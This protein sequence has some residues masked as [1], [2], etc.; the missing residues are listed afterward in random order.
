[1]VRLHRADWFFLG[2]V[3]LVVVAVALLPSPRDRNPV[4]PATAA[5]RGLNEKDCVRCHAEGMSRPLPGRHPKRQD[6]FRCHR[7]ASE[8]SSLG[9]YKTS[10]ET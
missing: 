5:H 9:V 3:G 4:V 6:C 10:Y 8:A 2:A 7:E 1:M